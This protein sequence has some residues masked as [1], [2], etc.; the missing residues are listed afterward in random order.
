MLEEVEWGEIKVSW[1]LKGVDDFQV[2]F[3]FLPMLHVFTKQGRAASIERR[4]DN[5]AISI[6]E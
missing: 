6:A 5:Q 3:N 1:L 4:R 2:A